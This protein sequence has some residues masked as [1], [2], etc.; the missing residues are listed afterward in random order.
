MRRIPWRKVALAL[1]GLAAVGFLAGW[2]SELPDGL[3]WVLAR[4]G[5][6][7][8]A[9]QPFRSPLPDY[10]WAGWPPALE[11]VLSA[12]AGG[13]LVW[14]VLTLVGKLRQGNERP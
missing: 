10:R 6:A 1:L 7:P 13:L 9:G 11:A 12:V 3:E 5:L 2:A 14:G 8:E 4:L